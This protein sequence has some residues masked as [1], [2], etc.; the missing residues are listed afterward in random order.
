MIRVHKLKGEVLWINP[1]QILY[2]ES[3]PSGAESVLTLLDG[4]HVIVS[5][6]PEAVAEEVRAHRAAVL[7][8]AF[9]LDDLADVDPDGRHLRPVP[10]VEQ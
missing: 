6:R 4:R 2:V 10:D 7:A 8:L 3:A 5:D 9:R 1:E